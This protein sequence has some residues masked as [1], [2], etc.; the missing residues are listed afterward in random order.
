VAL[1]IFPNAKFA[2]QRHILRGDFMLWITVCSWCKM[3]KV[4]EREDKHGFTLDEWG[5]ASHGIC[6]EC[7]KKKDKESDILDDCLRLAKEKATCKE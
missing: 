1:A 7:K 5:H 6:P 3:V 2:G 4:E